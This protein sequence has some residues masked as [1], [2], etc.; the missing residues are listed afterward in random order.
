MHN[1]IY[2]I[3]SSVAS[4]LLIIEKLFMYA[5]ANIGQKKEKIC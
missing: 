1:N 3:L 5:I 4:L 2:L